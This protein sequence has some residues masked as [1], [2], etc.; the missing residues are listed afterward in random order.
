MDTAVPI[1]RFEPI[2]ALEA[3]LVDSW[4]SVCRATHQF[5]K[6]LGEFDLRQGWRA[7]G[8]VD[9]ADWL[10]WKCGIS[11]MTAQEKVR[12][13]AALW[14][15]PKIDDAFASGE[16]SYSK[17]RAL[18][19]VATECS[20]AELLHFARHATAAQVERYCRRLRNGD[21]DASAIDAKRLHESRSLVR[22]VREDGSGSITVELP[23]ADLALVMKALESVAGTLPDDPTRSLFAKGAD[24]LVQMARDV[25]AGR[26]EGTATSDA[27]QVL[28]HVDASA[29]GR[30]GGK[31]D[32]PLP[33]VQ[34]LTCDGSVVPVL[35]GPDGTP[36]NVGRKQRTVPSAI[37]R[38]LAARDRTCV[39]PGC[40]HTRFLDAHHVQHWAEGG[41]TRL[42]NLLLLCST[43]HKLVHEGGFSI[44]RR[45]DGHCYFARPDGRPIDANESANCVEEARREYRVG[46]FPR[47]T[48]YPLRAVR[49]FRAPR[50][51]D[52]TR[53]GRA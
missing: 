46:D 23:E 37:R 34:R 6:L 19:R 2:D 49:T 17:V 42:D 10:N 29:L 47:K 53:Y 9:C 18:T 45:H 20:E 16:L 39:F 30:V 5:L 8:N 31:A 15:L 27:Y 38:A 51:G 41:E 35:V 1:T 26:H 14:H 4:K 11:R 3:H 33:T 12:V 7:Y 48:T 28:V 21:A 13:A 40:H 52:T 24:A 32:L 44:V 43:H 25:L 36:L 22:H 50:S